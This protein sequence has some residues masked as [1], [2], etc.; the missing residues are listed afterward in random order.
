MA[1]IPLN[2]DPIPHT[3]LES[4]SVMLFETFFQDLRVGFRVLIKEKSFC[5]LAVVVLAL[6]IG[7]VATMFSVVNA[8]MLRGFS[9]PNADRL[10][11]V[12][13]INVT[14]TTQRIANANGFGSQIFMLDYEEMRA[15]QKSFELLAGYIN[16]S[17]VNM[18]IDG[19]PQRFTGAYVT[20]DFFRI[21]GVGPILG[22]DFAAGD[23]KPG[24]E[25]VALISHELWQNN[26]GSSPNVVGKAVIVNGT[27]ATVIGVM[28]PGFAFPLNE[29]LWLPLYSEFPPQPR[30][31]HVPKRPDH[32]RHG[33]AP[34][35]R[36][37]RPG[38]GRVHRDREAARGGVPRHQQAL[39]HRA[40]PSR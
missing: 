32:R 35:R 7:G 23:N 40:R 9:F 22:R 39:R 6:G 31:V 3:N 26:F 19:N 30:N 14:D 25:K 24:A 11:G 12:Q 2:D 8:T 16:G 18:T 29:Q 5:L 37:H 33:P 15:E 13:V 28:A 21:L 1:W 10:A 4:R 20:P 17:T 38:A 27:P 36:R 34:P